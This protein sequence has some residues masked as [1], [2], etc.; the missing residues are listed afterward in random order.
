VS[1]GTLRVVEATAHLS[2]TIEFEV[3]PRA[4]AGELLTALRRHGSI[5]VDH[6]PDVARYSVRL[7][8]DSKLAPV[9]RTIERWVAEEALRA[10][11]FEL[12]GRAYI[13][14]AGEPDWLT[15]VAA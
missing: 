7:T 10:I 6:R 4:F 5:T 13:L 15:D 12:D 14:T 1:D 2:E 9:L 3:P 8:S 11:R